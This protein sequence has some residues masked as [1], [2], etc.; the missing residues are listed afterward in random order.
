MWFLQSR[1]EH[2]AGTAHINLTVLM[3]P[4]LVNGGAWTE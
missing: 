4:R 1:I 2:Y 3:N